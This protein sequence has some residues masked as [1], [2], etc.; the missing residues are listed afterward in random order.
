MSTTRRH[1]KSSETSWLDGQLLIAMPSMTDKRFHRSVI[2]MCSHS[3]QG[4]MGLIV[5][6]MAA[7]VSFLDLARELKIAAADDTEAS[8]EAFDISVHCGGPVSTER[9]FVLHSRDYFVEDA[10]LEISDGVCLTATIDI[11]KAL[12]QGTGPRRAI[13]ALGYSGWAPGQLEAEIQANGWLHG[14]A[15]ADLI[16]GTDIEL[17]YQRAL[18]KIGVDPS[19]LVS[20]AGHA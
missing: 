15:D 1:R 2:Y 3:E 12:Y 8:A 4:A 5:N 18:S 6:Q 11:V 20:E 9:G 7:N 14:P 10:T 17:K 13:L 16:F 19:H